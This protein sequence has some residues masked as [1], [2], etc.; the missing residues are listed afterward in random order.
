MDC[1][2]LHEAGIHNSVSVP[3]GASMGNQK[4]EYLDNCW[5]AFEGAKRIVLAVDSDAAGLSLREELARRLGKERCYTVSYP[6]G[7][8]DANDVLLKHGKEAVQALN[9]EQ[10]GMA[11]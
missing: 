8:K 10:K 9:P 3:N 11:H 1:L 5:E 7:C 6:D 4:L 2:S